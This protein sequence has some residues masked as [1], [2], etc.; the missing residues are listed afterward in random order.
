MCKELWC[1]IFDEFVA[2]NERDPTDQEM[3]DEWAS[4]VSDIIDSYSF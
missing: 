3:Q 2:E 4:R 1:E